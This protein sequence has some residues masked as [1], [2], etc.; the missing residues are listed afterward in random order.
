MT[1]A[2]G[3]AGQWKYI[4]E[5]IKHSDEIVFNLK[6]MSPENFGSFVKGG[7]SSGALPHG[8][9]WTNAELYTVLSGDM[10]GK[11]VHF[12]GGNISEFMNFLK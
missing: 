9:N 7:F 11:A 5:A 2:P 12:I 4:T 3:L 10:T 1:G 6:G 8:K